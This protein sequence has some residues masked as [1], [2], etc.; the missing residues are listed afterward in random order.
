MI[1]P[2]LPE[3]LPGSMEAVGRTPGATGGHDFA[4][5]LTVASGES[6]FKLDAV[7]KSTGAAGPFQF[8]RN[9]WLAL[10]HDY[11][12]EVGVKPA[13]VK[14]IHLDPTGRPVVAQPAVLQDL[15]ALRH[16]PVLSARME[17]KYLDVARQQL[18]HLLH[19]EPT[20]TELHLSCLLGPAGAAHLLRTAE[21]HPSM[22]VDQVVGAAAAANP[23]LFRHG[24]GRIRTAAEAILFVADKY[25]SDKAHVQQMAA[26]S[27]GSHSGT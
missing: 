20:E 21:T 2:I 25:R 17:A 13:L 16:D 1:R 3:A 8:V 14:Q 24:D 19:R 18:V 23:S 9:T 22:P 6:H 7:N 4:S 27:S 12:E 10:M 15:L 5:L 26:L 11:G